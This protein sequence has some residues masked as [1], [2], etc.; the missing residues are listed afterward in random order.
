MSEVVLTAKIKLL[1]NSDESLLLLQTMTA[2]TD[3]CNAVSEYIFKTYD[4]KQ[5]SVNRQMYYHLR[6]VF[7]L[8]SQM[9]QSVIKTVIA[10]YRSIVSN[11]HPWVLA[12]FE[13]LQYDL[14]WNR[15]YSLK[16]GHF[17]VNTLQGRIQLGFCKQGLEKYFNGSAYRF[18]T[19]KLVCRKDKFFLHISVLQEIADCEDF[20]IRNVV[21]VDRGINFIVATYD[22]R[23]K[24]GFVSGRAIKDRRKHYA[25]LRKKL[26]CCQTAS[27]RRRLKTIGQRENRWMS[28]VNHRISK[29]LVESQPE[30]TLFVLEDLKGVRHATE[31]V[32]VRDRYVSVSWAFDD[33][34]QKIVYKAKLRHSKV[35]FVPPA[36]TSQTCPKCG[37]TEKA[38]RDK[39]NHVFCCRNCHYSSN[40]DRVAAMNLYWMGINYLSNICSEDADMHE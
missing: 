20:Q 22:S 23:G 7:G 13:R 17:S 28:D 8:R 3:A 40:D 21:G 33:L 2:Y 36:Y 24:S 38:N 5:S 19:A 26:Q 27:A 35:I 9:A 34:A 37:H 12:S 16:A 11:G 15:D 4:L 18:G 25:K 14:V 29:A 6:D 31:R 39:R 32:R 1:P 30:G 10:R